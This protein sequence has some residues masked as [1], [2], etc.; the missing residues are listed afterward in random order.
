MNTPERSCMIRHNDLDFEVRG[1]LYEPGDF[2]L[3][4]VLIEFK[5]AI[6]ILN[7]PTLKKLEELACEKIGI[8][9]AEES[10]AARQERLFA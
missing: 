7:E 5:D 10:E 8:Q 6:E 1:Y 4:A 9:V 3:T 2:E